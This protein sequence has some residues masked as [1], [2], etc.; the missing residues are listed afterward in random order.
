MRYEVN[1]ERKVGDWSEERSAAYR[2]TLFDILGQK[3]SCFE[4]IHFEINALNKPYKEKVHA[5]NGE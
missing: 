3:I 5:G 4:R 2:F 1:K